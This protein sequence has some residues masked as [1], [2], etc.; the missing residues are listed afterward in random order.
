MRK[1]WLRKHWPWLRDFLPCPCASFNISSNHRKLMSERKTSSVLCVA[2]WVGEFEL[3]LPAPSSCVFFP[4][5]LIP[6]RFSQQCHSCEE[7]ASVSSLVE[8]N[9]NVYFHCI[10]IQRNLVS[11]SK[12]GHTHP[13][14]KYKLMKTNGTEC[15]RK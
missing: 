5:F 7:N 11:H 15:K 4:V 12:T 10:A 6:N 3:I 14:Q 1:Y 9:W 2:P 8:L 13:Y